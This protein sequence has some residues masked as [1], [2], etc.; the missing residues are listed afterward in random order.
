MEKDTIG[1]TCLNRGCI[2][3]KAFLETASVARHVQHSKDFGINSE[4]SGIDFAVAHGMEVRGHNLVWAQDTYTPAWVR[5]LSPNDLRTTTDQYIRA[6]I[7]HFK[8]RVHRWDVVNEP[9]ESLG[10]GHSQ[11]VYWSLGPNWIAD[12]FRTAHAADPTAQ[13]WLN[14]FGTDWVPGKHAA[15]LA[16]VTQLV[17]DGVP[18]NG[19]GLQTHRLSTDGPDPSTFRRQLADFTAL[20]VKVAITEVDVPTDPTD[21]AAPMKQAAAYDRIVS[22]CVAV[23]GCEEVTTWNLHDGDTWLDTQ[24]LF[25]TPTRPLLFDENFAPKAAYRSVLAALCSGRRT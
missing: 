21:A 23:R 8:D 12:V 6:V 2:P 4:M 9:L 22:A 10:T 15:L 20:G 17:R 7:D 24:G 11:S 5:A 16:L 19:V 14:E 25:R 18:I 13:L 3:A 1:G